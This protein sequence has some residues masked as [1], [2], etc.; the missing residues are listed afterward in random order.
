[1]CV[2]VCGGGVGGYIDTDNK[3]LDAYINHITS[4]LFSKCCIFI[5]YL[6]C[7][8]DSLMWLLLTGGMYSM[9]P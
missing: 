3:V 9:D 4:V 7:V 6:I 1:M 8:L 5:F 2:C